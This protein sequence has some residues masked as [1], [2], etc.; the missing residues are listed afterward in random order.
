VGFVGGQYISRNIAKLKAEADARKYAGCYPGP[1]T[2]MPVRFV[3]SST[4]ELQLCQERSDGLTKV[5]SF[6]V[7]LAD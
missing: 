5:P 7:V 2:W 6:L 4:E 3:A 1:I